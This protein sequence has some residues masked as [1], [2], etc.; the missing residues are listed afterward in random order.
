MHIVLRVLAAAFA[1]LPAVFVCLGCVIPVDRS[2]LSADEMKEQIV[3]LVPLGTP[4][5]EA[6]KKLVE[7]GF[8]VSPDS[9]MASGPGTLHFR[10]DKNTGAG[11]F[12]TTWATNVAY[13][14]NGAVTDIAVRRWETGP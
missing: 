14:K 3:E 12:T 7:S 2:T 9:E 13:D 10:R 4:I 1:S 11:I 5:T 6:R 8:R